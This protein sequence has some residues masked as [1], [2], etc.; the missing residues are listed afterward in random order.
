MENL[1]SGL[2]QNTLALFRALVSLHSEIESTTSSGPSPVHWTIL[3][4]DDMML[5]SF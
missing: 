2:A 4:K 3:G 5:I 1:L